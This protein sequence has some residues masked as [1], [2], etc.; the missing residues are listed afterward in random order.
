MYMNVG[1]KN[2]F[3]VVDVVEDAR[4]HVGGRIVWLYMYQKTE[5]YN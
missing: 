1:E 2:G 3:V 5:V 4:A